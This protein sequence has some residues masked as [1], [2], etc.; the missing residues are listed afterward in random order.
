MDL[1]GEA[2]AP[3]FVPYT[4][5]CE[6]WRTNPNFVSPPA[7]DLNQ[8]T[9][10][11]DTDAVPSAPVTDAGAMASADD[12][13]SIGDLQPITQTQ[14][15]PGSTEATGAPAGNGGLVINDPKNEGA[16]GGSPYPIKLE[17]AAPC[18]WTL[19]DFT[20]TARMQRETPR[21][22]KYGWT[23]T[24]QLFEDNK[25]A[26]C[27]GPATTTCQFIYESSTK[28]L[29]AKV[30]IALVPRLL[31]KMNL[32]TNEPIRDEHGKYAVV[33]YET[34]KNGANS[35]K[36]FKE[37]GLMLIERDV[38]EV[39]ASAYKKQ[40]E[41]T[42]NQGSYKLIL[43]GCH[44]GPACGCR[45]SV[46]FCADL[47]VVTTSGAAAL[48]PDM[49]IDLFPTTA[50]ADARNWPEA[51]YSTKSGIPELKITQTK[52]HETGHLFNFPD[53]YWEQGGFV[54]SMYVK[55]DL[56]IDFARADENIK[57]NNT[58]I[59]DTRTNLMG[60]G[61]ANQTAVIPPYYL[62]YV[63]RWLSSYTNKLWRV[64]Y[65]KLPELD[66]TVD[67]SKNGGLVGKARQDLGGGN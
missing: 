19:P 66:S 23:R 34:F 5:Q 56:S 42:L 20:T 2:F 47:H 16:N 33:Q 46:K 48:S 15:L 14:P 27:S 9:A 4:T 41:S 3:Q 21:Y 55:E 44:K 11:R 40:I 38:K 30:V 52:A 12:G 61:A 65:D 62:E 51:D 36:S 31:V 18:D 32:A 29:T 54:H 63:R 57:K 17:S 28:T 37:W 25:P 67:H 49:T 59:I 64:G 60:G 35:K 43:D 7:P 58:W 8:R 24:N 39:D 50:R 22:H 53:E 13:Y 10:M 1:G 45:I 26:L 6:V